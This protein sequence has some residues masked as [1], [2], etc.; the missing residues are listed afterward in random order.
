MLGAVEQRFGRKGYENDSAAHVATMNGAIGPWALWN[1]TLSEREINFLYKEITT[2][3]NSATSNGSLTHVPRTYYECTGLFASITGE[4]LTAWWDGT[5][6][7][8]SINN[9]LVDLHEGGNNLTG[10]GTF[11]QGT[12]SYVDAPFQNF[13]NPTPLYARFGGYPGTDG[14]NYGADNTY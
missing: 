6:G 2:P 13:G 3:Y 1:R 11:A 12:Q 9:G 5:T 4:N 7:T 8:A 14:F 10:S